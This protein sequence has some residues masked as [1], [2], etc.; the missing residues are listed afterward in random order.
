[1]KGIYFHA[2]TTSLGGVNIH[3]LILHLGFGLSLDESKIQIVIILL[4]G[5]KHV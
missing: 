2:R 4:P 3:S 1:M 5:H